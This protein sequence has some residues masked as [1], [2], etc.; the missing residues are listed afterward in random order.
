[1]PFFHSVLF[2]AVSQTSLRY[3][4][5]IKNETSKVRNCL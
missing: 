4:M 1:M 3:A 5:G 2:E